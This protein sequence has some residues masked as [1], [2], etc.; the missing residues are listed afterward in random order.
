MGQLVGQQVEFC[1][2]AGLL[3]LRSEQRQTS[4][5]VMHPENRASLRIFPPPQPSHSLT[6]LGTNLCYRQQLNLPVQVL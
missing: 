4:A 1:W 6:V 2:P 3:V 5:R